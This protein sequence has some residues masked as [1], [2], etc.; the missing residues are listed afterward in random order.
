MKLY[1]SLWRNYDVSQRD[2]HYERTFKG[3]EG[4]QTHPPCASACLSVS[5]C[6]ILVICALNTTQLCPSSLLL[7]TRVVA[8]R[9]SRFLESDISFLVCVHVLGEA[10]L[11]RIAHTKVGLSGVN[12][13][14]SSELSW[15]CISFFIP[16]CFTFPLPVFS[17]LL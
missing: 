14:G 5:Q 9:L 15:C 3:D 10:V 17:P 11:Q 2:Y 4:F 6:F 16:L 8:L 1:D 13:T 7:F 12:F